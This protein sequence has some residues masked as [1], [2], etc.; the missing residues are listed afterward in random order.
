MAR[1]KKYIGR[2]TNN[3]AEYYELDRRARLRA[4]AG[5]PRV[6]HRKRFLSY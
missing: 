5:H 2:M 6:A 1:L 3:V 4:I